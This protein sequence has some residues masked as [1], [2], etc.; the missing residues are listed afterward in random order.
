MRD[1]VGIELHYDQQ[2]HGYERVS[3]V[4]SF[5]LVDFQVKFTVA[6]QPA[7]Q[8]LSKQLKDK[9][10]MLLDDLPEIQQAVLSWGQCVRVLDLKIW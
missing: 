7:F 4:D 2:L 10:S 6:L 1:Q 8:K 5:S 3:D 9:V